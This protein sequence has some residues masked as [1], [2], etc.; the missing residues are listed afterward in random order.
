[1]KSSDNASICN[2]VSISGIIP[3]RGN[4]SYGTSKSAL[5]FATK[6]LSKE[7]SIYNIRVNAIA[8][9]V[10]ASKMASMMDK[11]VREQIVKNSALGRELK[12]SEVAKHVTFLSSDDAKKINGQ[13]IKIDGE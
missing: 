2:I 6:V 10:V 12:P 5:I 3:Q 9:G 7:L 4:L 13:I 1:M 11:K 8:P